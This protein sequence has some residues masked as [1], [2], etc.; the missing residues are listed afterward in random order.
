MS[1]GKM[2]VPQ[3]SAHELLFVCYP[4][5]SEPPVENYI[6]CRNF[7]RINRDAYISD[8]AKIQWHSLLT[9]PNIDDKVEFFNKLLIS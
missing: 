3:L 4:V 2:L 5:K 9:F 7:K 1:L 6:Y 8:A